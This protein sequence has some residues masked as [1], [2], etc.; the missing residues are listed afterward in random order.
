[1]TSVGTRAVK[2]VIVGVVLLSMVAGGTAMAKERASK[3]ENIGVATGFAVGAA[4]GGPVGA[5][6]GAAT[7]AWLGDR[8]HKTDVARDRLALDLEQ[9]ITRMAAVSKDLEATRQELADADKRNYELAVAKVVGSGVSGEVLFRTS[10]AGLADDSAARL[11]EVGHLLA[12]MPGAEVRL[13]GFA[14]PR[15]K[16]ADNLTL[17]E[18]RAL[19]VKDALVAGGIAPAQ[20]IVEARGEAESRTTADDLDGLALERKVVISIGASDTQSVQVANTSE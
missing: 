19:A 11:K 7:G 17:S 13:E 8:W 2:K 6:L 18:K 15:G 16:V 5:I 12:S 3:K 10:D 20:I 1:M 9:S 14:D 4:A